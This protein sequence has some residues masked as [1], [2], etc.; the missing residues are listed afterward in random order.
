MYFREGFNEPPHFHVK[1]N[2]YKA[3]ISIN[4]LSILK[5][6]LPPRSLG[7]VIKWA[8]LHQ[9]ELLENWERIKNKEPLPKIEPLK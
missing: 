6:H 4:N 2:E 1:Y 9:K 5:G 7:L 3:K 8:G